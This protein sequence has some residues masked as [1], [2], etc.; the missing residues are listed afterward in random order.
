[1]SPDE[2]SALSTDLT[3]PSLPTALLNER[4]SLEVP[5]SDPGQVPGLV[6]TLRHPEFVGDTLH[7][8]GAVDAGGSHSRLAMFTRESSS[9]P[10]G[11][12]S[13]AGLPVPP[14]VTDDPAMTPITSSDYTPTLSTDCRSIYFLRVEQAAG[15]H[16]S[17]GVYSARR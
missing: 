14:S 3:D 1:V 9:A 8:F 5:F 10:F 13:V 6:S 4:G 15:N 2:L 7:L 17:Y 16:S 12:A 11:A